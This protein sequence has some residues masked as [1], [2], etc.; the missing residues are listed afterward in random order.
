[1][2]TLFFVFQGLY[3][4]AQA[5]VREQK[6]L[7]KVSDNRIS[8]QFHLATRVSIHPS[9]Q[10]TS[11]ELLIEFR[12]SNG[13]ESRTNLVPTRGFY[14]GLN[15]A[16]DSFHSVMIPLRQDSPILLLD[17]RVHEE[18]KRS[19]I[20]LVNGKKYYSYCKPVL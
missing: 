16:G 12:E 18:A 9:D 20:E 2:F 1:M 3:F 11:A 17:L 4:F 15:E 8:R 5:Q 7:C 19:V 6:I 10:T 14:R 13:L